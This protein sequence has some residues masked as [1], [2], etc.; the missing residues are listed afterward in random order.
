VGDA[1][2]F[3]S[4]ILP[5]RSF[6]I[7]LF[8]AEYVHRGMTVN[9]IMTNVDPGE[10]GQIFLI[11]DTLYEERWPEHTPVYDMFRGVQSSPASVPYRG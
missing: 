2:E 7:N 8:P 1:F 11:T 4:E 5:T 6:T 9:V 3:S 10:N